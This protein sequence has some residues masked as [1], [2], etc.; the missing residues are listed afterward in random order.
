MQEKIEKIIFDNNFS[1]E[2]KFEKL[3]KIFQEENINYFSDFDDTLSKNNCVFYTKVKILK[4]IKK[5]F[6]ENMEKILQI[7]DINPSFKFFH[8]KIIIISR[9]DY[10]FLKLFL[11]NFQKKLQE[12]WIEIVGIIWQTN[13]FK[14]SSSEKLRFLWENN[15][16]IWDEFEEKNL[17]NFKNFIFIEKF[18]F[19]KK[20]FIKIKKIFILIRFIVKWF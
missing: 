12:K 14:Y 10:F 16:F 1:R 9:N 2:E 19:F 13:D 11:K 3:K 4:K 20:I 6:P 17:Q 7:F 15:F 18:S 8:K 5:F